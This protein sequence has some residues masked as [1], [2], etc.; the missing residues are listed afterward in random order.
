M[1]SSPT[2]SPEGRAALCAVTCAQELAVAPAEAALYPKLTPVCSSSCLSV[3]GWP[4]APPLAVLSSQQT[5]RSQ[6]GLPSVS[7]AL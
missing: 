6:L 3:P 4:G 7:P 2:R 1:H 5:V